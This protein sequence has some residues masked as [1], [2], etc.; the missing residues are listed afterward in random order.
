M[1]MADKINRLG[2]LFEDLCIKSVDDE[3]KMRKINVK[4]SKVNWW[5]SWSNES[6]Y[7]LHNQSG[8][9]HDSVLCNQD[10]NHGCL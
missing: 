2:R 7:E 8:L 10:I 5:S 3:G 6:V 1:L 9:V 4:S